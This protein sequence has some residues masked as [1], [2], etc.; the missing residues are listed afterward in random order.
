MFILFERTKRNSYA[1]TSI[2]RFK[3]VQ[4]YLFTIKCH[5]RQHSYQFVD[6]SRI[7]VFSPQFFKMNKTHS[8][9][10]KCV[11]ETVE[12]HIVFFVSKLIAVFN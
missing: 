3:F 12:N 7:R 4:F 11:D 10:G 2:V 5:L 8:T 9:F 1:L 6:Q